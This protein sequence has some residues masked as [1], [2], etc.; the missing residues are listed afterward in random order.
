MPAFTA[1]PDRQ[2]DTIVSYLLTPLSQPSD[3]S[4]STQ[5]T[6]GTPSATV[7][8]NS[9]T[10]PG[11]AAHVIGNAERGGAVFGN[12]CAGCHSSRG[13]GGILNPGS[14]EGKV[15]QL[16]PVD[17]ELYSKDPKAFAENL[18]RYIQHGSVPPGKKPSLSMPAFGDTHGLTQQQ[19]A[20]VEAYVMRLN[21]V[22]RSQI[23]NPGMEPRNFFI[24]VA[25]VYILMLFIQGG[26]RIKSGIP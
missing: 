15:P 16:N 18:D 22:D 12:Y 20:N 24:L 9:G 11:E 17:R 3:Q 19:I 5:K 1:L 4:G 10:M 14:D 8:T 7:E 2:V 26:I 21:S 25:S 23:I 13:I 6:V